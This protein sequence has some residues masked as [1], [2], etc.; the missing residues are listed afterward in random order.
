MVRVAAA[1]LLSLSSAAA[2][3]RP[4]IV[5]GPGE[6]GTIPTGRECA[7]DEVLRIGHGVAAPSVIS[8]VEAKY[9]DEAK[10]AKREG[11][12]IVTGVID[13][14]GHACGKWAVFRSLGEGLDESAVAAVSKWVFKPALQNGAPAPVTVTIEVTFR[15]PKS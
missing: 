5:P 9:T 12:V 10:K 7:P 13:Q 8:K 1:L 2:Q 3:N 11:T 14:S 6:S 15:L 4:E